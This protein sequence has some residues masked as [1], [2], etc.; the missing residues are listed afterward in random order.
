MGKV[1]TITEGLENMGALKTGGQGSVYKGRRMGEILSAVKLLPTPI[2]AETEEDVNFKYF[3]NEVDKLKKVN[4]A[5]NPNVVKILSAGITESGSL[6]FIEMEYIE[7]PDL[8]DLLKPP[9]DPIFTIREAIKVADH[10]ANALAH[11]HKSGVK[12]GD[13]KSNN[14]KYSVNTGNYML[15][16]FGLSVMSEEQR[17]TSLRHAGAIEFMAPEQSSGKV[18]FQTDVYSYGIVLFEILAGVVPFPLTGQGDSSRNSVML[19]HLETDV[20]DILELRKKNLPSNWLD[21]QKKAEMKVP[22][23][24][25]NIVNICLQKQIGDRFNDGIALQEAIVK[26][27]T[28]ADPTGYPIVSTETHLSKRIDV[29]ADKLAGQA[30]VAESKSE[31]GEVKSSKSLLSPIVTGLLILAGTTGLFAGRLISDA[32]GPK[33]HERNFNV[34]RQAF[35]KTI[36]SLKVVNSRY[37]RDSAEIAQKVLDLEQQILI[38]KTIEHK[39]IEDAKS[40]GKRKKNI[41]NKIFK[42][43]D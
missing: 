8:E 18:F 13:I 10:L 7:G 14:V 32:Y 19:S 9:H 34:E 30:A 21:D 22:T 33:E 3:Q 11:C 23:W 12:H 24:L 25:L 15:L 5:P 6:P 39:K 29:S 1:F 41:F 27:S 38:E 26:G 17:R 35:L 42:K 28:L 36:D 20:P 40:D 16:D 43:R 4:S 31:L 37:A 2:H